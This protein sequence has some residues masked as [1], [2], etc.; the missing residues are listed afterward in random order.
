MTQEIEYSGVIS[1]GHLPLLVRHDIS[2]TLKKFE[3]KRINISIA[4]SQR[5]RTL[6]QN[7]YWF[8]ILRKHVVPVFRDYGDNWD[9]FSVHEY[10]MKQLG[11]QEIL[12]D[13]KGNDFVSRTSSS[14]FT[15]KQWE[16]YMQR[17][18]AY[19]ATEHGIGLPLPNEVEI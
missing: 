8:G 15:T 18:R 17:A 6:R 13:H 2:N 4:E 3:G 7:R 10:V 14:K 9:E 16:D 11:Y 1:K 19:L 5:K 12:T